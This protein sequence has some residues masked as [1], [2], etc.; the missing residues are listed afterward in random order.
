MAK[1]KAKVKPGLW[2]AEVVVKASVPGE[3]TTYE[4]L[5]LLAQADN[6]KK[7]L[8]LFEAYAREYVHFCQVEPSK[9]PG[10]EYQLIGIY[11]L[12]DI[13]WSNPGVS[14]VL[15]RAPQPARAVY[16]SWR[17]LY[18]HE[19]DIIYSKR[20]KEENNDDA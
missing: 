10:A 14:V 11:N 12:Q 2:S 19:F 5:V 15:K 17:F 8:R 20:N 6:R 7:A 3:K 4:E 13:D 18:Q 16:V 1:V 9:R